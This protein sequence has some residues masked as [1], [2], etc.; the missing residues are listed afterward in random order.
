MNFLE[1]IAFVNLEKKGVKLY[2]KKLSINEES[3]KSFFAGE[4]LIYSLI[5]K[6]LKKEKIEK[7]EKKRFL[8]QSIDFVYI[9]QANKKRCI[10]VY[11]YL[12]K[13]NKD[14]TVIFSDL[15]FKGSLDLILRRI[16]NKKHSLGL[17]I[18]VKK[19]KYTFLLQKIKIPTSKILTISYKKL[20]NVS[21]CYLDEFYDKTISL[22]KSKN[23]LNNNL[24][25]FENKIN[26]NSRTK[27]NLILLYLS[28]LKN[29]FF[30]RE[31]NK[32]FNVF[33]YFKEKE[34]KK[35]KTFNKYNS[36]DPFIVNH[37]NS[38]YVFFEEYNY[39]KGHISVSKIYENSSEYLGRII[40]EKFHLSFPFILKN[41][42]QYYLIPESSEDN[43]IKLY[44]C[45]SFPMKWEFKMNIINNI[46]CADSIILKHKNLFFILTSERIEGYHNSYKIFYS[47]KLE[48]NNWKPHKQNPVMINR[49]SRNAGLF[50]EKSK[51]ILVYQQYDFNGYGNNIKLFELNELS[52]SSFKISK[53]KTNNYTS[54]NTNNTHHFTK[55]KNLFIYDSQN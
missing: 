44:S 28:Y 53:L 27:Y 38:N 5:K 11:N 52:E 26:F 46:D 50:Y 14:L 36:A 20:I 25:I 3:F 8:N 7:I 10:E 29:F 18:Y 30:D 13:N 4:I 41:Q 35:I 24:Q 34:A 17:K 22:P 16:I 47:D 9:H 55:S 6:I 51:L 15:K 2:F 33:Y 37:S 40:D 48:T 31:T 42:S 45:K 19:D 43:S 23:V 49:Y 54:H 21:I 32:E 39:K 12:N 1:R